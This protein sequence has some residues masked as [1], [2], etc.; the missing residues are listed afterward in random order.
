MI[1]SGEVPTLTAD[2]IKERLAQ[3]A[4]DQKKEFRNEKKIGK[5]N[6]EYNMRLLNT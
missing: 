4:S 1:H 3:L 6:K 2:L 5:S